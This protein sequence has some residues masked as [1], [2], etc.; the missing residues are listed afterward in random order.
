MLRLLLLTLLCC[1]SAALQGCAGY[2]V[3]RQQPWDPRGTAKMFD[4]I[5]PWD[6]AARK[7]CGGHLKPEQRSPM[8]T[9]RC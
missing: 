5:P 8:M 3:F 2:D 6:N 7:I 9:D 1:A 4:Q